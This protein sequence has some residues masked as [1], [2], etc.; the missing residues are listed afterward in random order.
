VQADVQRLTN[1]KVLP[2]ATEKAEPVG[3]AAGFA[4]RRDAFVSRLRAH[5]DA[6]EDQLDKTKAKG[7]LETE[8][9]DTKARINKLQQDLDD[10]RRVSP[11][12]WWKVSSE[13]VG[14]YID[15]VETSIK[16]LDDNKAQT[17]KPRS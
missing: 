4:E 3:T 16:R 9:E 10:L 6:M 2:E 5:V 13:R 7:A 12:A 14:E 17:N 11:E 15:R 8:R 1:Q